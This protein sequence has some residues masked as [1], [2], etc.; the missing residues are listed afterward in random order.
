MLPQ[1][2]QTTQTAQDALPHRIARPRR[3]DIF[4]HAIKTSRLIGALSMDRRISLGR[5]LFFVCSVLLLL[6]ILVFPDVLDEALLSIALP[7]VGTILGVPLDAGFD[8]V[9]F[10]LA[11]V[12][13]LRIFPKEIVGE[14]YQR[15]FHGV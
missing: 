4:F 3:R 14:H 13:L 8:W 5:K 11:S 7:F 9:A 12:S 2:T 10:A 1:T 6:L 15:L